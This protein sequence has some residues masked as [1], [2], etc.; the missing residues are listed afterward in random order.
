MVNNRLEILASFFI[1]NLSTSKFSIIII[2]GSVLGT[3]GTS[4]QITVITVIN[5][6]FEPQLKPLNSF[7]HKPHTNI[8]TSPLPLPRFS[9]SFVMNDRSI[10]SGRNGVHLFVSGEAVLVQ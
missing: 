6:L 8:L 3:R 10:A 1:D 2:G 7:V 9:S 4:V 5:Y